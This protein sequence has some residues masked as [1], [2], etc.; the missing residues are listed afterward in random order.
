MRFVRTR[1]TG[2]LPRLLGRQ[3]D[4]RRRRT[5]GLVLELLLGLALEDAPV[6]RGHGAE[7]RVVVLARQV[8]QD[9]LGLQ[10]EVRVGRDDAFGHGLPLSD[11]GLGLASVTT[12]TATPAGSTAGAWKLRR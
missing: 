11:A 10:L 8:L 6:H 3:P 9:L 5:T 4:S 2:R 1:A 7:V 12:T